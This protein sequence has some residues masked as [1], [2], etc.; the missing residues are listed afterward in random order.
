VYECLTSVPFNAAVATRF[1]QYYNDTLQFHST[2][3]Y[4]KNPPESY[5][6]PA[7]DVIDELGRIQ[8]AINKGLFK[9]Q[10]EFEATLESL[11]YSVHDM[12]L[13]L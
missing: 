1:I 7:V 12:H 13:E 3:A 9:N 11:I 10:Y 2:L 6:Q 4:L 8:T 5:Q